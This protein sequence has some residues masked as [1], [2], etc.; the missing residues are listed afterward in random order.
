MVQV[1]PLSIALSGLRV[2]QAQISVTSNNIANVST[3]GYTRKNVEQYTRIIGEEG[4]GADVG[5]VQRRINDILLR[6]YRSQI[7][8]TSALDTKSTYLNQVQDLH[9]PPDAEQ[10]ITAQIGKLKDA[11]AQ[12][13]NTPENSY[14]LDNVYAEATQTIKK[15]ADFS[16]GINQ[17]RNDVQTE[18]KNSVDHINSL[19]EQIANLNVSIKVA[20]SQQRSTADMEDQRDLAVRDLAKEMDI[21]YY[22]DSTGVITVMTKQGQLL[23]DTQPNTMYFTKN[24]LGPQSYYPASANPVMI[25]NPTT[26]TDL[27]SYD[28]LGGKLGAL[29]ELRDQ[30]LPTFQAQMDELAHKMAM[31]FDDEGLKLFTL[32]DGSIPAN[33]PQDYVGFSA[34]MVVNPAVAA[35]LTLLR[36]GTNPLNTVQSGSSELLS[37]IVENTFGDVAYERAL[38]TS[39]ISTGPATLFTELGLTGQARVI[40]DTNIQALG[41]LDS[42]TF[43]NPGTN[44]TFT[45]QVGTGA[46]QTITITSGMTANGLVTAINTAIPGMAQLSSGGQL[47]LTAS[48]D[49]TIG[50]GTLGTDGLAELGLATGVTAAQPPSFEVAAGNNDTTTITILSTDTGQDL[51]DKLNAVPG[52]DAQIVGGKLQIQPDEGGS[53]TLIDRLNQPLVALGMQISEVQHTPFNVSGLGP[54]G[55]LNGGVETATSLIDYSTQAIGNQSNAADNVDRT[56]TTE[57]NYRATIEKQYLDTTGVNLDEEMALLINIQTAYSASARTISVVQDMLNTLMDAMR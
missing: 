54:G 19:T 38:G 31:R 18:M 15:F 44:D 6:D 45:I 46:A 24:Q 14:L 56:L 47:I 35:D 29:V 3:D 33:N 22:K 40:G 42:S 37:K 48:S 50:G 49:I 7:S 4:A 10:T 41:S 12:L 28:A 26:G 1:N 17:M 23:A 9:G 39:T 30:T 34:D 51:L 5:I 53:I 32:P 43:I 55:N 8:L 25:G 21:S 16:D 13:A 11:F 27:T 57:D 20:T 36:S 2:A 52:I